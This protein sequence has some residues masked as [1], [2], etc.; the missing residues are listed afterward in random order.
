VRYGCILAEKA[1][2]PVAMMCRALEVKRSGFYAWCRRSP[3]ARARD[4]VKLVVEIKASH[5]ESHRRY[6]SPRVHR[7]LKA[8]G[9]RVGKNRIA[10]LMREHNIVARKKRRFRKTTD[11]RHEHP[12]A[13]NVLNRDFACEGPNMKWAGDIT[14][15]WTKEGWLYLAAMLDLYSRYAVGWA[16]DDNMESVLVHRALDM[17][18]ARRDV[19]PGLM[20]HSDRGV[21][22]ASKGYRAK[23]AAWGMVCS[24]SRKGD[25]WDNAMV[26]SFFST[27]KAE[28]AEQ[29]EFETKEEARRAI[30]EY[31]EVFYNRKRRHSA[32]GY[33]SPADY[34]R[35][36]EASVGEAA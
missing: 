25:C 1:R 14:Y 19:H 23:E 33:Q 29:M 36:R 10:R 20:H 28:L 8:R 7:D 5:E 30:F 27:L 6:G 2:M 4:E 31:I 26:E 11:S 32:L 16:L 18:L 21:Q 9:R 12:I 34:E 24:M 17:A 3:S 22:F 35:M 15:I 13:P